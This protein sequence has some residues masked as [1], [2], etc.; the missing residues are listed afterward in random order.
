MAGGI[1]DALL[2][3]YLDPDEG[4]PKR[5]PQVHLQKSQ[6]TFAEWFASWEA[7][8]RDGYPVADGLA[9]LGGDRR[10]GKTFVALACV[11]ATCLD[12]PR[13]PDGSPTVAWVVAR[14]YRERYEL[15][16]WILNRVPSSYY[17]HRQ[18]PDH[19]FVFRCGSVLR[20]LSADDPD[21]LKQGR[22]DILFINEPQKMQPRAV[23]NALLGT[24]DRGGLTILAAN[25]P[26][27][28]DSRGEWMFDVK[29]AIDDELVAIRKG[30]KGDGLG[31]KYFHFSSKENKAIDQVARVR[32]GRVATLIDPAL[33][34]G[35]VEGEWRRPS[36]LACWEFDKHRHV[37][38]VPELGVTDVTAKVASALGEW[39]KWTVVGGVDFQD[40]PHIV[41]VLWRLFG[42]PDDPTFWAVDEFAGEKRW[43]TEE[44]VEAFEDRF[45]G[46]GRKDVLWVGDASGAWQG[47]KHDF[48]N[49]RDS[50][51]VFQAKGHTIIPPQDHRGENRKARNPFVD[52]RLNL[53]NELLR[54]DKIKVDPNR[55]PWL[56]DCCRKAETKREAGRRKL[57]GNRY[58][59]ALDAATYPV[60]R[61]S[62]RKGERPKPP[63]PGS[64]RIVTL[65]GRGPRVL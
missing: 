22:V 2:R 30:W 13:T 61:L 59:H 41:A 14:S 19:V 18:A 26:A 63:P 38:A 15:E 8:W 3:R 62:P 58:A 10:G 39:G 28:G 16:E 56:V 49:E 44:F 50:F 5:V 27:N 4:L 65:A 53:F 7:D 60:W 12:V 46:Y 40:S 25:P 23:A 9:L 43:T 32:A 24:S 64:I 1:W 52:E 45:P 51:A 21:A 42:D 29:E 20:I 11:V 31:C 57:V 48:D 54:R 33:K 34:S 17:H 47:P 55:C 35:D 36:D 6:D 37:A